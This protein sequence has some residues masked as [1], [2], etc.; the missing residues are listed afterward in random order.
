MEYSNSGSTIN[1]QSPNHMSTEGVHS[2]ADNSNEAGVLSPAAYSHYD[3]KQTY[4]YQNQP[5]SLNQ[6]LQNN[7]YGPYSNLPLRPPV[8]TNYHA[9]YRNY[10]NNWNLSR[11][12]GES[13]VSQSVIEIS[14]VIY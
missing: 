2:F 4:Q 5:S 1:L 8:S 6:L 12:Q 11:S 7:Q 13:A 9:N 14:N 3:E 10:E